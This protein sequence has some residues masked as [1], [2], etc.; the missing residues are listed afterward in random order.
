MLTYRVDE[1]LNA[2]WHNWHTTTRWRK[3]VGMLDTAG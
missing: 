1:A 3:N 2:R